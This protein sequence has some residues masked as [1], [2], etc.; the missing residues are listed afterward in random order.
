LSF[1]FV[2]AFFQVCKE[3]SGNILGYIGYSNDATHTY[4]NSLS[5]DLDIIYI[6]TS[7]HTLNENTFSIYPDSSVMCKAFSSLI[8]LFGWK[9]VAIIYDSE[10]SGKL[11]ALLIRITIVLIK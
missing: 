2:A 3:T 7:P 5:K 11:K 6:N 10:N 9:H 8:K 1:F 4:I